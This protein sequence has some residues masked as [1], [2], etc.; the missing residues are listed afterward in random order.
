LD[1]YENFDQRSGI[2]VLQ[3]SL[4]RA[5]STPREGSLLVRAHRKSLP[6]NWKRLAFRNSNP[7][8]HCVC[9]GMRVFIQPL[10]RL[11][12]VAFL[13][14]LGSLRE[15]FG[16]YNDLAGRLYCRNTSFAVPE[17]LV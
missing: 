6:L 13:K 11:S 3:A 5:L 8:K 14:G 9:E 1:F 4:G 2:S 7:R 17:N 15:G 16:Q 10:Q 12:R